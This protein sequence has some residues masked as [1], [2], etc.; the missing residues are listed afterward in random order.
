MNPLIVFGGENAMV[1]SVLIRIL[2][3]TDQIAKIIRRINITIV[4]APPNTIKGFIDS[5]K[6][7]LDP[8]KLKGV[9]KIPCACEKV[10]IGE[11][12]HSL[13]THVKEYTT[14]IIDECTTKS[15]LVEHSHDTT[16]QICMEK[17]TLLPGKNTTSRKEYEK[18]WRSKNETT[19]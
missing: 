6:D 11:T 18:P 15:A 7:S 2:A 3:T 1:I 4:F 10:Y 5:T 12:G 9:Y 13:Q 16:H 14:D 8:R 19:R 17:T